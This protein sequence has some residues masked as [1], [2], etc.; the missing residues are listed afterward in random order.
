MGGAVWAAYS[1][2]SLT[3]S[4]HKFCIHAQEGRVSPR[5]PKGAG[6]QTYGKDVAFHLQRWCGV[7][8][9]LEEGRWERSNEKL[10]TLLH[11]HQ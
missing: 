9:A 1:V 8:L 11:L 4:F 5:A 3:G 6:R 10:S 7:V 2:R